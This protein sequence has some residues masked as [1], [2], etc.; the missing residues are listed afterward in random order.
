MNDSLKKAQEVVANA[1]RALR[2][3]IQAAVDAGEYD[4]VAVLARWAEQLSQ[5]GVNGAAA[6]TASSAE[7][8]RSN[9]AI[10]RNPAVRPKQRRGKSKYPI[11]KRSGDNLVKIAWSKAS[12][13]EYQHQ[14]S[15]SLVLALIGKMQEAQR[16]DSLIT[17]DEVLPLMADDQ[18]EVPSYQS[19]VCLA[20]LR[21]IG[22]VEQH[23]RRGYSILDHATAC[24]LIERGW[25][26]LP[27]KR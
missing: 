5:I 6:V 25:R 18:S 10:S 12:K 8:R 15:K 22:V 27:V 1:E 4:R 21:S 23:G 16:D 11:F 26:E 20:W 13:S 3:L 17:M 14:A 24:E 19:Y 9:G 2:Q 7:T